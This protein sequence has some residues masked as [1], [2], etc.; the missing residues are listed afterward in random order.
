MPTVTVTVRAHAYEIAKT[1]RSI[2]NDNHSDLNRTSSKIISYSYRKYTTFHTG[3]YSVFFIENFQSK[4]DLCDEIIPVW[5]IVH[6]A[7]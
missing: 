1:A 6:F 2:L 4:K 3:V 7:M 5:N